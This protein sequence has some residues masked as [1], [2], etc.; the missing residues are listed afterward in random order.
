MIPDA[1]TSVGLDLS[2]TIA[3]W[4]AVIGVLFVA[5]GVFLGIKF[6]SLEVPSMF[7]ATIGGLAAVISGLVLIIGLYPYNPKY[8]DIYRVDGQVTSISNVFTDGSSDGL[9]R[10]PVITLSTVPDVSL[11]VDDPRIINTQ[12]K[13][14][15]LTCNINWHYQAMDTY[16]CRLYG[17][18]G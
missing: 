14:V 16:E 8:Y 11:V 4:V 3:I 18:E 17:I 2:I 6:Y 12:D 9:T 10:V 5:V 15:Q 1:F 13:N 7:L